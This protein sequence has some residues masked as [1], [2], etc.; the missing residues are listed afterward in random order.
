MNQRSILARN[1]RIISPQTGHLLRQVR[2]GNLFTEIQ[3]RS[4]QRIVIQDSLLALFMPACKYTRARARALWM[5]RAIR[6]KYRWAWKI[7]LFRK[8]H[9]RGINYHGEVSG[10]EGERERERKGGWRKKENTLESLAIWFASKEHV[11]EILRVPLAG[12]TL[13]IPYVALSEIILYIH[14]YILQPY[15]LYIQN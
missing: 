3:A 10:G 13:W 12:I 11:P 8:S 1:F 9:L 7:I 14:V 6:T 15:A 4:L 5:T 2:R